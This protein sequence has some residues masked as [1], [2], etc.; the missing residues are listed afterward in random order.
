MKNEYDK[1][2]QRLSDEERM[3]KLGLF[4]RKLSIDELPNFWNIIRGDMSLIGPRA[5][6]ENWTS[7]YSK[8]HRQRLMVKPGLECPRVIKKTSEMTGHQHQFDNDLWYVENVSL[9]TDI[10]MF[11]GVVRMVLDK[12]DRKEHAERVPFFAGYN[13]NGCAINLVEAVKMY[14]ELR[15]F[16][17]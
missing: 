7:R 17:K 10:K 12:G 9:F 8:R 14:P 3:T 5:M 2:G 16:K 6:P 13:D 4:L 15:N 1:K 11:F